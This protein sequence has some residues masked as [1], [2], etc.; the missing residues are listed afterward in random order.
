MLGVRFLCFPGVRLPHPSLTLSV[1]FPETFPARDGHAVAGLAGNDLGRSARL[2]RSSAWRS[3]APEITRLA[4]HIKLLR[5]YHDRPRP[6]SRRFVLE[7]SVAYI[8][9]LSRRHSIRVLR[10]CH[11]GLGT[12]VSPAVA[13]AMRRLKV[14]FTRCLR[15]V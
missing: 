8:A 7:P 12:L 1:N 6:P 11:V 3:Q 14:F 2:V 9:A 10:L 5:T 13:S 4:F 15:R